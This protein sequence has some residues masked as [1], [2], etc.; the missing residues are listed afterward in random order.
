MRHL[1]QVIVDTQLN[2][3]IQVA[4]RTEQAVSK[5]D[6]ALP[7]AQAAMRL[8]RDLLGQAGGTYNRRAGDCPCL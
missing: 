6:I 1:K 4:T 5:V 3:T 2:T 7:N 8:Q